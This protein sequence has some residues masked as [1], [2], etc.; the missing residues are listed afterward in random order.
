MVSYE[1]D[2]TK[3]GVVHWVCRKD[4]I[5]KGMEKGQEREQTG[6]RGER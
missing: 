4:R 2:E 5:V 1:S 6:R 3:N